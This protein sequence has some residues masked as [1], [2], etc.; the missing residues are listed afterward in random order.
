MSGHP[1]KIIRLS[2]ESDPEMLQVVRAAVE[3]L[4]ELA[5]F[6]EHDRCE[7]VLSVDE[8][9]TN[10]IRHAYKG[11]HNMPVEI[12][13]SHFDATDGG[14]IRVI[15]R[16]YGP[17]VDPGQI[18]EPEKDD[19]V[20]GGMGLRIMRACMDEIAYRRAEGGGMIL[21]MTKNLKSREVED[22]T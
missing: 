6:G 22:Q 12:A 1:E 3:K 8:G 15:V 21:A 17:E 5:G 19:L 4:A 16:D 18:V 10:V 13:I 7:I 20:P 2:L 11:R 9:L 14:G